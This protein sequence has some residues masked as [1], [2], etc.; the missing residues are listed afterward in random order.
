MPLNV[1]QSAVLHLKSY[2]HQ[3]KNGYLVLTIIKNK[4]ILEIQTT[5]EHT[6]RNQQEPKFYT[7]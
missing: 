6:N 1:K 7:N 3:T 2:G 4:K 5:Q